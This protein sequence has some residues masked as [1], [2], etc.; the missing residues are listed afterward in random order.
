M[1]LEEYNEFEEEI[2][3][4]DDPFASLPLAELASMGMTAPSTS[5]VDDDDVSSDDEYKGEDDDE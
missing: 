5:H 1:Q 3:P 2:P 4:F